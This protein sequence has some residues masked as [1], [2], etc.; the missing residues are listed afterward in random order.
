MY[1]NK[2]TLDLNNYFDGHHFY[3]H[4]GDQI[5]ARIL[6]GPHVPNSAFGVYV[7][8]ATIDAHLKEVEQLAKQLAP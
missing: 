5:A 8:D 7:T 2:V 1:P 6:K 4:V 3:P